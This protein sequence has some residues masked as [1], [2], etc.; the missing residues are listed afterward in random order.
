ME[1]HISLEPG[2]VLRGGRR[3]E[4]SAGK[5]SPLF[6][7]FPGKSSLSQLLVWAS[8]KAVPLGA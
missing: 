3:Q 7:L 6:M 8:S 1:E 4:A 5:A 2:R